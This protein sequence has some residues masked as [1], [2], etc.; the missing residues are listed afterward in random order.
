MCAC[1]CVLYALVLSFQPHDEGMKAIERIFK[2]VAS[3]QLSESTKKAFNLRRAQVLDD[4]GA[5]ASEFVVL[6]P[7]HRLISAAC[8][9]LSVRQS[10]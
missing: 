10:V 2:L 5:P 7:C 9:L 1:V 3:S 4:Y 6:S 8:V